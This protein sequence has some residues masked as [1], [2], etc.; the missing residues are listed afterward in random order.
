MFP[1]SGGAADCRGSLSLW[2]HIITYLLM[3]VCQHNMYVG[4]SNFPCYTRF[5]DV[6]INATGKERQHSMF[7]SFGAYFPPLCVFSLNIVCVLIA[8]FTF[9]VTVLK[10]NHIV[11]IYYMVKDNINMVSGV[12]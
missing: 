11:C 5:T 8:Y 6:C 1:T 3:S 12:N 9:M 4:S 7:F 2:V 10:F